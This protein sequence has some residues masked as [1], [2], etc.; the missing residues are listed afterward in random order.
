MEVFMMRTQ[1]IL[2][3]IC[4]AIVLVTAILSFD[5]IRNI[6]AETE[7]A[8]AKI[9]QLINILE[10]HY[11]VQDFNCTI[12]NLTDKPL[13]LKIDFVSPRDYEVS[14]ATVDGAPYKLGEPTI[15][16]ALGNIAFAAITHYKNET[17]TL[18]LSVLNVTVTRSEP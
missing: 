11:D 14:D 10:Y 6:S 2:I 4:V 16:K 8:P 3:I 18:D 7:N 15:I 1:K 12:T 13:T 5:V 17:H 9:T